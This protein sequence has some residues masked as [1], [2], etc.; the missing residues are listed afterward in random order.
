MAVDLRL[1]LTPTLSWVTAG[2]Q[3]TAYGRSKQVQSG[4]AVLQAA[5]DQLRNV[6]FPGAHHSIGASPI[7]FHHS[8]GLCRRATGEYDIGNVASDLPGVFR[9]QNPEIA[10]AELPG[11]IRQI[12]ERDT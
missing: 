9:L 11:G 12:V 6:S 2:R 5:C 8:I 3:L 1:N 10:H 7:D 4:P